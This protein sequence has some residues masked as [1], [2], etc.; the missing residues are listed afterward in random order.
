MIVKEE[1]KKYINC[2]DVTYF[3]DSEKKKVFMVKK[4]DDFIQIFQDGKLIY[5]K[6]KNITQTNLDNVIASV[7][8][9]N[10]YLKI[11]KNIINYFIKLCKFR[12]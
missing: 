11:S 3:G 12:T 6:K 9:L 2:D 8:V 4:K 7:S 5:Y 10:N 1:I